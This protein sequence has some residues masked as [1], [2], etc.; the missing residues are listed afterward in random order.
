MIWKESH[1]SN[2]D[3]ILKDW[4]I[5]LHQRQRKTKFFAWQ[6][7]TTTTVKKQMKE[8]ENRFATYITDKGVLA[9]IYK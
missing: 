7:K 8:W 9:L 3:T 5:Q 4:S 2:N 6:E 1:S